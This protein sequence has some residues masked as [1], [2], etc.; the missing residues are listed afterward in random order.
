M[1]RSDTGREAEKNRFTLTGLTVLALAFILGLSFIVRDNLNV[2]VVAQGDELSWRASQVEVEYLKLLIAI[3]DANATDA[4]DLDEVRKRF[5]VFYSR[6][7]LFKNETLTDEAQASLGAMQERLDSFIPIID[8]PDARLA[9]ALPE[10]QKDLLEQQESTR[11]IALGAIQGSTEIQALQRQRVVLLLEAMMVLIALSAVA[12]VATIFFLQKRTA[13]Q[14]RASIQAEEKRRQLQ[15]TLDGAIGGIVVCDKDGNVIDFNAG[16]ETIFGYRKDEI[17]GR[18]MPELL[19]PTGA[20]EAVEQSMARYHATGQSTFSDSGTHEF[21]MLRADG[22]VFPAQTQITTAQMQGGAIFISFCRDLTREKHHEAELTKASENAISAAK[23]RSRFFAMMSHEMRTPL[24][25]VL[26]ALYLLEEGSLTDEQRE[27]LDTA[28]FSGDILLLH[29]NDVLAIERS[30][31]ERELEQQVCDIC[32]LASNMV[33]ML[34]PMAKEQSVTLDLEKKGLNGRQ[35]LSSPRALQQILINLLSNAIK[36]SPQGAVSLFVRYTPS[37]GFPGQGVLR[38]EVSD[39]GIGIAPEDRDRIFDDFVSLDERYERR[40]GGTGLGLGIVRRFTQRLGGSIHCMSEV[41]EGT[42][43]SLDLPMTEADLDAQLAQG[44]DAL[45][46]GSVTLASRRILVVDDNKVNRNVME[47]MLTL[48]GQNVRLAEGGEAAI[49]LASQ[50][51]F[52]LILMDISMPDVSGTQ[53]TRSIRAGDGPNMDTPI[54]AFTAHALPDELES[55]RQAGMSGCLMKPVNRKALIECIG[56]DYT[57]AEDG[58]TVDAPVEP[59]GVLEP[60]QVSDL[61]SFLGPEELAAHLNEFRENADSLRLEMKAAHVSADL[62]RLKTAA[63]ALAGTSGMAGALQLFGLLRDLEQC[64][65]H[66]DMGRIDLLMAGLDDAYDRL[67]D[68]WDQVLANPV[69]CDT[70][71]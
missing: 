6:L 5:D 32:S 60:N 11:S 56:K 64:C 62:E 41:G 54:V 65:V 52:D 13:E 26:S 50:Q 43:F 33:R 25:G 23:E 35:F 36:F 38:L 22:T 37:D 69:A 30:E 59:S 28:L 21:P 67:C 61:K 45:R 20:R 58:F 53:A 57:T 18:Y 49:R 10:F 9:A 29:I 68:A 40:T 55:F 12:I 34:E 47:K 2:M 71:G 42:T 14:R 16:A 66:M 48:A 70:A 39:T 15:A 1:A 27:H 31:D 8:G 7:P 46:S 17:I 44:D 4:P 3:K 63:H 19:L 51:A 24:N